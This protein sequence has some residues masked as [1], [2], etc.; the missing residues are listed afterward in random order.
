MTDQKRVVAI[1]FF[2]G[3]HIGHAALLEKT[4]QRALERGAVPSVLSFD[5]HP[6][7]LVLGGEVKLINSSAGREDIIKRLFGI[8][9]V[10][11]LHFDRRLMQMPWKD[12]IDAIV[13]ELSVSWIVVGHDFSF[14]N[15][16][17]GNA[18]RLST[19]CAELGI[20]CDIIPPVTLDGRIVSSTYIRALLE[21]GEIEQAN[22][23]LGHPH[24][25][26]DTVRHGCHLGSRL[27]AP[28][29]NMSFP[30]GVLVPRYGVYATRVCLDTG[31]EYFA[32]TNVGVRPTT[33]SSE[34]VSVESHL[35]DYSG[36]LYGRH[37]RVEFYSFLRPERKF[38]DLSEL[39]RQIAADADEA[40][41]YFCGDNT[42]STIG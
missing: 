37:V 10:I 14:G 20:G 27:G 13:K 3:V 1:G 26:C 19:Y 12:F 38:D 15:R 21:D 42:G 16:G 41:I 31:E 18:Q 6:D 5:V 29:I 35:L 22:R 33:G 34:G 7:N 2:D 8:D 23:F 25:L 39:S 36:D 24:T 4:K 30:T 9:D 32:V 40:R 11:F 28:T 17:E